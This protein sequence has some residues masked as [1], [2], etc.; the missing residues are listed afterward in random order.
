MGGFHMKKVVIAGGT[1]FIGQ[2]FAKQ[3][4]ELGY[5]VYLISRKKKD[6]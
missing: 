4:H 2:Y 3:F 5:E 1:G 6:C